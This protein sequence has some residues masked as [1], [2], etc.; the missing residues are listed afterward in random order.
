MANAVY[1]KGEWAEEFPA[2]ATKSHPFHISETS[3]KNVDMMSR[4]AK[5][6]WGPINQ[7]NAKY[8]ELPYKGEN[9]SMFIILPNEINGLANIEENYHQINFDE[10]SNG[11]KSEVEL[12][13]PKF[14]FQTE[15][16]LKS[17]LQKMNIKNMFET[18]ANFHGIS[19]NAEGLYVNDVIQKTV[20]A[21]DE[22]GTEAAAVTRSS[23]VGSSHYSTEVPKLNVDRPFI[24]VIAAKFGKSIPLFHARIVDPKA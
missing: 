14:S 21:V 22:Q 24:A 11:Q 8:I 23:L 1:F 19:D 13:M 10:Y 20:I 15:L 5:Y 6:N 2:Y 3:T 16:D 18:T 12:V 7:F 9:A 17:T 4:R